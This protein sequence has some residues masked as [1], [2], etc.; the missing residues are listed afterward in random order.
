MTDSGIV[1]VA[2][3]YIAQKRKLQVG[4]KMAGRHGNKGVVG[5]IVPIEDMPFMDVTLKRGDRFVETFYSRRW[6]N[7]FA[8]YDRDD[9]NFKGWYCNIGCPAV[10]NGDTVSYIDLALDL[11]VTA[12]GTQTVLDKDEFLALPLDGET[13]KQAILALEELQQGFESKEPPI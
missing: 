6:Y 3:V 2:K 8:I 11:W 9:G 5:K 1:Q 12:N 10:L 4:D 7:T 13:R